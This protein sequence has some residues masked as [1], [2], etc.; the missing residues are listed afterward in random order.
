MAAYLEKKKGGT[1]Q[2]LPFRYYV[3][4]SQGL[5]QGQKGLASCFRRRCRTRG[6]IPNHTRL[7]GAEAA[8]TSGARADRH[9]GDF[10]AIHESRRATCR[11]WSD[12]NRSCS[13]N[14]VVT[15]LLATSQDRVNL[16]CTGA[17]C[18]G[19]QSSRQGRQGR[20]KAILVGRV[21]RHRSR[22]DGTERTDCRGLIGR[23]TGAQQVRNRD[24]RNDQNDRHDDQQF[25]KGETLLVLF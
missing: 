22:V 23:H 18:R 13:P 20:R 11:N 4:T 7:V 12:R 9:C 21:E 6:V 8:L 15:T 17:R 5:L 1:F 10:V 16:L 24:G 3:L 19:A 25:D 2:S 14:E